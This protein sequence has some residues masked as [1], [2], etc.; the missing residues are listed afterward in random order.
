M[1]VVLFV[2]DFVVVLVYLYMWFVVDS[3]AV[4]YS[5]SFHVVL[6]ILD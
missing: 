3:P 6:L 2:V 1:S 4:Y 5:F